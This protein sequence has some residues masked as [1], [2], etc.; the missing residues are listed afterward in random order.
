MKTFSYLNTF[1]VSVKSLSETLSLSPRSQTLSFPFKT[2][3]S[4][5]YFTY[6]KKFFLQKC[7]VLVSP[8]AALSTVFCSLGSEGVWG[9]HT[10]W[11]LFATRRPSSRGSGWHRPPTHAVLDHS[12]GQGLCQGRMDV[13]GVLLGPSRSRPGLWLPV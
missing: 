6:F 13:L 1:A 7:L 9:R 12:L 8:C 3:Y 10:S 5:F 4:V 2:F 11:R